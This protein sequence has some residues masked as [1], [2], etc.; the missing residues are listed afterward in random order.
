MP[1]V[2]RPSASVSGTPS[3]PKISTSAWCQRISESSSSPSISK[4]VARKLTTQPLHTSKYGGSMIVRSLEPRDLDAVVSR[5]RERLGDD[6]RRNPLLSSDFSNE[7][8]PRAR[9]A[10]WDQTWVAD[11]AG[12]VVGHLYGALLDSPEYGN[13]AWIGPDGVSFASTDVLANLYAKVGSA[14]IVKGALEHYAWVFDDPRSEEH[15]SEL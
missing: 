1:L 4:I 2:E 10:A 15:T 3:E 6:A 14:W 11:D 7:H 12:R 8:F 13:G 9:G 5:V